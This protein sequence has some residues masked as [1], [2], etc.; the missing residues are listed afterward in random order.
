M[1]RWPILASF[2]LFACSSAPMGPM[3]V[4]MSYKTMAS[5]AEFP[6]AQSCAAI[7]RIDVRDNRSDKTLG[8]RYQQESTSTTYPVTTTSDVAEWV[9]SGA[10]AAL[11]KSNVNVSGR[12]PTVQLR[13]DQISVGESV[14]RRAEYNGRVAL[15][16]DVMSGSRSCW[17]GRVDGSS[18]NYGYAGSAE[19]YQE[20]LN[21]ALDR[22]MISLL[23][24][25]DFTSALC[26]CR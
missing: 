13:V 25:S 24:N 3:S 11:Q 9:K 2:V 26:N 20:T 12:G 23:N 15:T 6:S 7:S 1:R 21:H 16:A 4:P 19:N 10:T 22:A 8:K 14:Y 17:N 18:Q 5:P